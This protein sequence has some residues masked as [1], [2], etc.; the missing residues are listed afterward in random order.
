M[1]SDRTE[2]IAALLS[3]ENAVAFAVQIASAIALYVETDSGAAPRLVSTLAAGA[4]D[5]AS[6]ATDRE[7][8]LDCALVFARRSPEWLALTRV[9]GRGGDT[10]SWCLLDA[11][12][13]DQE[14]RAAA[15][16]ATETERRKAACEGRRHTTDPRS[17]PRDSNTNAA[18]HAVWPL[19]EPTLARSLHERVL[20]AFREA[21][22]YF[23]LLTY[24]CA[25]AGLGKVRSVSSMSIRLS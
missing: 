17:R 9:G 13:G 7:C 6:T 3:P 25:L 1:A 4:R 22:C 19:V 23:G 2:E 10:A 5:A 16:A 20:S 12:G 11:M 21:G 8:H 18:A 24:L 14:A 15:E